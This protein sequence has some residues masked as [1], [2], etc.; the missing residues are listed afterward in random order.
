MRVE[1]LVSAFVV[2]SASLK[3]QKWIK[4]DVIERTVRYTIL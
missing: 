3:A 2:A 4:R 1:V